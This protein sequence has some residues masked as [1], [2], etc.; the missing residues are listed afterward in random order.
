M[1]GVRSGRCPVQP[2]SKAFVCISSC[3]R[4][5]LAPVCLGSAASWH[6]EPY[7]PTF[8]AMVLLIKLSVSGRG[9]MVAPVRDAR[10]QTEVGHIYVHT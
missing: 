5:S 6:L 2:R 8:V 3:L 10:M 1:P 7:V 9:K 4:A